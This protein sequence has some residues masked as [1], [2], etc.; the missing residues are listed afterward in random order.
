M[1]REIAGMSVL[2]T[3]GGSGIGETVVTRLAAAGAHLTLTGRRAEK[4]DAVARRCG[5]RAVAGDVTVEADRRAMVDAAVAHGGDRL[6][7]IVHGAAN[8][9]RGPLAELTEQG[10]HDVFAS[11]TV[12]PMLLTGL[13]LPHLVASRG[14]VVFFGS[15]HT[16][17]AFPGASPYAATK[18]ALETLTGVL[19]AELGPQGVRVSCVR[20]GG[21]LTEI[22]QRA[23]I[24]D[25]ATAAER[26][27]SLGPAHA[28]GR[29]GTTDEVAEAVEYLL[30]AEWVTGN[31]LTVD[32]GL[33]LG[34]TNA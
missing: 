30:G 6:D 32:G 8:M 3:G 11:N 33:G 14:A 12:A 4:I 21:V 18:G 5:A 26:M 1:A 23:G 13:A 31:V 2:V 10:L 29:P 7:A 25:D 16:Q 28:L 19:A 24:F 20:P 15:V 22:N 9:Y 27:E 34:V 17:R